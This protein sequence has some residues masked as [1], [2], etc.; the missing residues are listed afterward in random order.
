MKNYVVGTDAVL[1]KVDSPLLDGWITVGSV[2]E[3]QTYTDK[4]IDRA[5]YPGLKWKGT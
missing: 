2:K 4:Q 1:A 5:Q 3:L